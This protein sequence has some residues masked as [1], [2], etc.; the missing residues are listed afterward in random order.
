MEHD[1]TAQAL[2]ASFDVVARQEAAEQALGALRGEM[3]EVK[4]R[5]DRLGRAPVRPVI[6]SAAAG[7]GGEVKSFVDG[8]LRAG[9][10]GE[11]KSMVIG[12]PSQAGY[13]VPTELDKRIAE[14]LLR[15]SPIRQVAQVVQTSSSDYRKLISLGGTASGWVSEAAARPETT[16]PSFAEIV[17][18]HGELYANPSASQLMLDDAAFDLESWLASEIA[19]EFARAEGAAFISGTGSNQPLGFL[20]SPTSAAP[21]AS[22]PFG[23]LQ[24][25][26]SGDANGFD[27][28]PD[29]HLIDMVMSLNPGHRQGATWVMN[30]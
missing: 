8:Y 28:T 5:I 29:V 25:T 16:E 20:A 15:V 6:G 7:G 21:D 9:R 24:Y 3:A 14:V 10:D 18:P 27:A 2:D 26:P 19:R 4:S 23:T 12:T 22:R 17:P 30:S 1:D 13:L 11:L